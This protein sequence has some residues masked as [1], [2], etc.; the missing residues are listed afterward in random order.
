[1]KILV[2]GA[3]GFIGYH[4]LNALAKRGDH[5][6]V[7]ARTPEKASTLPGHPTV[8][9]WA[10]HTESVPTA[11]LE[12]V[13]AVINLM[14]EPVKGRFSESHKRRIYDSRI[15]GT[16][17]LVEAIAN[18]EQRPRLLVNASAI[19]YY[20]NRGS[21]ILTESSSPG[22]DFLAN[23]CK[24]WEQEA[25]RAESHRVHVSCVRIGI[26]L[27]REG[28]ALK[29]ML[30]PFKLGV[31]GPLAGGK[32]WMS[33]IHV[34]DLVGLLLHALKD[35]SAP[36]Y[37]GTAPTPVTNKDFTK[38]LGRALRRPTLFPVPKLALKT[39][40]GE[41]MANVVLTSARAIP[42]RAEAEGFRFRFPQIDAALTDLL[43]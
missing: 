36:A 3:T 18:L 9:Q 26:V 34:D 12:G 22:S 35:S 23:V 6:V 38:A 15:V 19:G 43:R 11:A 1:M 16:R 14:G 27:G 42:K 32:D 7:L 28:G 8:Y 41:E 17:R 20:G 31:G 39:L 21:E 5:A 30:L 24:A 29:E 2:T 33:W 10:G 40:L 25:Q 4:L 37:N 13:D